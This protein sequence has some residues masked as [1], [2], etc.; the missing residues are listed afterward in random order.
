[1]APLLDDLTIGAAA[2]HVP[3]SGPAGKSRRSTATARAEFCDLRFHASGALGEVYLARNAE[4]N[5]D[6]A[7]KFLS[8]NRTSDPESLRRFLQEAEV[9]GRLEHPGVVP[10]YALG[11]DDAGTP[12]YAM[13]FIRG[14]TLQAAVHT[15]HQ[16]DRPG[17]DPTGRSLALQELLTRFVSVCTTVAYA[18]NRGI[19]HRDLKPGNIMLGRF[20]ETLVVDWGLAKPFPRDNAASGAGEEALTPSSGSGGSG[21]DTPTVG[22]VGTLAYMSP[23]Q[24]EARWDLVGPSSDIFS[25]GAILYAILTG[26]SPYQAGSDGEIV[27]R[28]KRCQFPKPRQVKPEGSRS[29]EAI[30]LKAMAARPADRYA[31]ALDLAADVKRWL[32]GEP[33]R[34]WRE[35]VSIQARRWA[36]R[37]RT[38][39]TSAT[40]VLALSVVGLA[41]FAGV[42]TVKNRELGRQRERAEEREA[43]ALGAVKSFRDA[44]TA[45]G[46]LTNRPELDALR[47][48]LLKQPLEFFRKLRDQLQAEPD[49]RASVLERLAATNFDLAKTT[50]ELGSFPDALRSYTES[51]GIRERLAR[52]H[53]TDSQYQRDLAQSHNALANMQTLMGRPAEALKSFRQALAILERATSDHP[54]VPELDRD[55]ARA[56]NDLAVLLTNMGQPADALESHHRA[57][58]IFARLADDHPDVAEYQRDLAW[59]HNNIGAVLS[60]TGQFAEAAKSYQQ[61]LHVR[62]RLAEDNPST[63]EFQRDLAVS[64]YNLGNLRRDT[65]R[66]TEALQSYRQALAIRERLVR[67]NPSVSSLQSD[68]AACLSEIGGI[69]GT[70]GHVTEALKSSRQA[71]QIFERLARDHPSI[72]FYQT[73]LAATLLDLA[74]VE[75]GRVH[76]PA[77]RAHLEQAIERERKV[78]AVTPRNPFDR[79]V[80]RRSLLNLAKVHR[81]MNQPAE[82]VQVTRELQEQS[83]GSPTELY[84]VVRALALTVPLTR[85]EEQQALADEAMGTLQEAVAAGWNNAVKTCR[86]P[87]LTPLRNRADFRRLLME[88]FDRAFPADTFAP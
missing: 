79:Q 49:T 46:E 10:V 34:A 7:L 59:S 13:R 73:A 31:T 36:R 18:H 82:A 24:A 2:Q 15:F 37:H 21:S 48:A 17:H 74:T 3:T 68:L 75:M 1:L 58:A 45:N 67:D 43:L 41:G 23:E 54:S 35:P 22:A 47:K 84:D 69:L 40:A 60:D 53:P 80:L 4:L 11:T 20:D 44:V 6:V 78:L 57:L 19:L 72:V 39:V 62:Q 52:D 16:S 86:D 61:A 77:A 27:Q 63:Q 76:W 38:L 5:R 33:V 9:T 88:L 42:L 81:A 51:L 30:C 8:P 55:L 25:L 29:L 71:A 26:R 65:G 83:H 85:R 28:V 50:R 32:A 66:P 64:Y 70:A 14:E 87:D 56:H 12:C